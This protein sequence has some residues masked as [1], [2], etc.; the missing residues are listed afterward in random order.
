MTSKPISNAFHN[1]WKRMEKLT[2]KSDPRMTEQQI[3][4]AASGIGRVDGNQVAI[5]H[6][7]TPRD[8]ARVLMLF[9]EEQ[10][11]EV[12]HRRLFPNHAWQDVAVQVTRA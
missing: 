10:K 7:M 4:K 8:G 1:S 2:S 11:K 3:A 12:T 6:H 9:D 5:P